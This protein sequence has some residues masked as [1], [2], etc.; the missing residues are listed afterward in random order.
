PDF[1]SSVE[2]IQIQRGVGT[3]TNGAAAFGASINIQTDPI[4]QDAYAQI[5]NSFGSFNSWK[6]TVR[7]G[8]GL[9]D[10]K[11]SFD[12]RLSKISSDG[13]LDRA[14]SDL[15]SFYLSAGLHGKKSLLKLNV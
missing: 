5:D 9:I 11:F 1:A 4:N 6:N 8:T 3:P 13:F 14:R 15:K 12:A 2:N 10:E 7:V